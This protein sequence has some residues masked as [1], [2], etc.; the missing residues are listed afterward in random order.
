[1][2]GGRARHLDGLRAVSMFAI[3][4]D[5][6]CPES[7]PRIFPFEIFLF[8]FLVMT[9]FLVTG[10]L[11]RERDKGV[12]AGVPWKAQAMK[13]YQIRRGLR[14]LA[15]YYAA[16]AVA[17]LV[18]APDLWRAP[19]AYLLH[20]SNIHIAWLGSWPHGTNHFWS[21]AMQQQFYLVWPFFLWWTP[22]CLLP[23]M[24]L[25]VSSVGPFCRFHHDAISAWLGCPWPQTLTWASLDYFGIGALF[26]WGRWRG[27]ALE[28][29]LLKVAPLAGLA[30]YLLLFASHARGAETYGLRFLQQTF[31]S[32]G[33]CG[34]LAWALRGFPAPVGKILE[35]R[36]LQ[37]VGEKSYGVYLYHNIAPLIAG[38]V[39]FFLWFPPFTGTAALWL[40]IASYALLTW[41]CTW[42]SWKWIEAPLVKV[43]AAVR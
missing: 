13:V 40:R 8:F 24:M 21:L 17:A 31:L 32:L 4:W 38:K 7:W 26:A 18:M 15:P 43:R 10:S 20:V 11:L 33:L 3:C 23:C 9:G 14:I 25:L 22:R 37:N 28:S 12:A 1:M 42:L 6:W 39:L 36:F 35:N 2:S 41:L 30:A 27:L 19:L 29:P 34:L 16:L 5:H